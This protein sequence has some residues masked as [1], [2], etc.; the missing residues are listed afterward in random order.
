MCGAHVYLLAG[1][2]GLGSCSQCSLNLEA[3]EGALADAAHPLV[4]VRAATAGGAVIAHIALAH[5]L[6]SHGGPVT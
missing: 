3:G 4:A 5:P 2:I 1:G 6:G